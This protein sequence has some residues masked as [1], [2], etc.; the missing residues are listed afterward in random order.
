MPYTHLSSE[1][2]YQIHA[3][4]KSGRSLRAIG[5]VLGRSAATIS[6]ELR[7]NRGAHGYRP[8]EAKGMA[9]ARSALSRSRPRITIRQWRA[10]ARLLQRDWSPQQIAER[11][12]REG[13]LAI[14]HE[15][16]YTFVYAHKRE[17]G[18]LWSHLR[19]RKQRRKRYASGRD[20][21]GQIPGRIGIEQ[22]GRSAD[23]RLHRGHW[24]GDTMHGGRAGVV[25]LVDRKSRFT[26][27]GKVLRRTAEQARSAVRRRLASLHP[28]VRSITVDNGREFTDHRGIAR[29]LG[30]RVFFA[31]PYRAWERGTNEN[32]NGLIR[33]Y[34]PKRRDLVSLSGPEIRKIEN[35]LN[36]R[37]RR[38]LEYRT[39]H[40]VFYHER[41]EL[42]VALRS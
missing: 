3:L 9:W 11:C 37:P 5:A 1:E 40:E 41:Q 4:R 29:D 31:R 26:R 33:Q 32:T 20:R 24:E 18:T 23:R 38:C 13:T 39:P 36:H 14:S 8:A 17:G 15:W 21:R 30:T 25:S 16:I 10:I 35:R 6:R 2:R 42:T 7:R 27:L 19:V 12:R 28:R 22:R 34:L